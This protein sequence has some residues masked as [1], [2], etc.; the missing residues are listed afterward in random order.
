MCRASKWPS[1]SCPVSAPPCRRRSAYLARNEHPEG[2]R[3][4]LELE[5]EREAH[6]LA[7][8]RDVDLVTRELDP[9]PGRDALVPR[10]RQHPGRRPEL[11]LSAIE[12]RP[13]SQ[14][15]ER[16]LV[17]VVADED[18]ARHGLL[19]V[20]AGA[21]TMAVE[22]DGVEGPRPCEQLAPPP[23]PL[24]PVDEPGVDPERHVV[25]EEAAP[26]T[27]DVDPPLRAA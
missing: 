3:Q 14:R 20:H 26:H 12:P 10:G 8:D 15:E 13:L 5:R 17:A 1:P 23:V 7:V 2:P 18:H 22:R 4:G 6:G 19:A 11:Q 21:H 24:A 25:Q 16:E 9:E 27:A